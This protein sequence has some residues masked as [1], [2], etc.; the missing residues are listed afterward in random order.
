MRPT[1]RICAAAT[2]LGEYVSA[3]SGPPKVSSPSGTR[4]TLI[5]PNRCP[6]SRIPRAP[7]GRHPRPAPPEPGRERDQQG[8]THDAE[9]HHQRERGPGNR[10]QLLVRAAAERV[11][12]PLRERAREPEGEGP[13][14]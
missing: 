4:S 1:A 13:E 9:R 14:G 10:R 3:M 11:R 7:A 8:G 5:A 12:E 6:A 2:R